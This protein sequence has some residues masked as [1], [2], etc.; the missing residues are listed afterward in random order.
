MTQQESVGVASR[1]AKVGLGVIGTLVLGAIGSG[2]W[3]ILFRPG[4][5]HFGNFITSVSAIADRVVYTTAALDPTPVSSLVVLLVLVQIPMFFVMWMVHKGFIQPAVERRMIM[6]MD[7]IMEEAASHS[8][9]DEYIEKRVRSKIRAIA[10]FGILF[11]LAF[12]LLF[13]FAY[14]IENRAVLVWRVFHQNFDICKPYLTDDAQERLL[15]EFRSM[16]SGTDFERV[17]AQL[18]SAASQNRISLDW[19]DGH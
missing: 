14:T 11:G 3:E 8:D 17:R 1:A 6:Q 2:I 7:K 19:R 13:A 16:R 5:T 10:L 9:S 15:A 4:L 18:D 12:F